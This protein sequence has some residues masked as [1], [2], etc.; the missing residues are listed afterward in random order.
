MR[1]SAKK[2]AEDT[3]YDSL[4]DY[5]NEDDIPDYKLQENNRSQ[6]G[7]GRRNSFLRRHLLL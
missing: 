5:L 7:A 3:S 4:S 2:M 6:R 1:K